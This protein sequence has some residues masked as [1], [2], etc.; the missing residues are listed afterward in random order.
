MLEVKDSHFSFKR[1]LG[2]RPKK[3][4]EPTAQVDVSSETRDSVV[5]KDEVSSAVER[6]TKDG[7]VIDHKKLLLDSCKKLD[8]LRLD[9]AYAKPD[10]FDEIK[11]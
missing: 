4:K 10:N 6:L 3:S 2:C 1:R 9:D 7:S 8:C 5:E 11:W